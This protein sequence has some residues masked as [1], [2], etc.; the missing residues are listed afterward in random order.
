MTVIRHRLEISMLSDE[1]M[2]IYQDEALPSH[3]FSQPS[4]I[5]LT[6]RGSVIDRSF[7]KIY[8]PTNVDLLGYFDG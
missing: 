7:Y 4:Q 6:F 8:H 2:I 5:T 3:D 1:V